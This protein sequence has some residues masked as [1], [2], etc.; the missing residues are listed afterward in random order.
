MN[1]VYSEATSANKGEVVIYQPDDLTM[2][3]VKLHEDS[4]W[5]NRQQLAL[6]FGR[7]VKTI[8]KH[9]KNANEEELADIPTVAF[10]ATVQKEGS[11]YVTR[12]IEYYNLDMIL[13]VGYRVKSTKGILFRR[14]ANAVLREYMSNGICINHKISDLQNKMEDRLLTHEKRL[15]E[16]ER[17][18]DF[19]MRMSLPPKQ[20]VFFDGQIYDAYSFVSGL[21]RKAVNRIILIDNYIDDTVLT[22]LDKRSDGVDATIYTCRMSVQLQLDI[23]KHNAQYPV[24]EVCHFSRSHDRF[25]IIDDD[26]FLIGAS[27]KD[28]GKKWFGFT[29]M[30]STDADE[31]L[32][33]LRQ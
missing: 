27:V 16:C 4:V 14:W 2:I 21:I 28:L 9:I 19:F 20:G 29:L 18:I 3:E 33:R 12:D 25:L 8:G 23:A 17:K 30:E 22:L 6:L 31:L 10:F 5:L 26:V 24:I 13:S 1:I 15:G 7:D 11:R 32:K